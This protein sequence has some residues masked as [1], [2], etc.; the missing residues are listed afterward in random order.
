MQICK[1]LLAAVLCAGIAG[2]SIFSLLS[3][4]GLFAPTGNPIALQKADDP[5]R[6]GLRII[7]VRALN[8]PA[9]VEQTW[10]DDSTVILLDNWIFTDK[11]KPSPFN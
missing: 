3:G 5:V 8:A 6:N 7:E 4:S 2:F 1:K 10:S 9:R 11:G